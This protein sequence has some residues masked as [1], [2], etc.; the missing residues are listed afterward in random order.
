MGHQA[1]HGILGT[2]GGAIL[3]SIAED[4]LKDKKKHK[5]SNSGGHHSHGGSHHGGSH[6]G[7]GGSSNFLGS[8]AGSLFGKK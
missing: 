1:N 4:K 2:I 6:Y 7:G 3:G 5:H 8:A